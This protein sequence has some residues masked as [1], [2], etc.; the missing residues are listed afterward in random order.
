MGIFARA[1]LNH[2]Q[3]V[4]GNHPL[5]SFTAVGPNAR[6]LVERQ[7]A[8]D[9]YAPLWDLVEADG[10]V[11]MMGTDL[12]SATIIHFAE[13]MAGRNPFIRWALGP[14][15]E[16]IPVAAGSC[17]DGFGNFAELLESEMKATEVGNS[18]WLCCTAKAIVM[19]CCEAI[20]MNPMITHCG[21]PECGRCNDAVKGGPDWNGIFDE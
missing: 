3:S 17:S 4:R 12:T 13:Q 14:A 2:P 15:G 20:H 6:Q 11:L 9:V 10:L 19:I 7:S 5:N 18:R 21:D 8:K 1:V 16:V